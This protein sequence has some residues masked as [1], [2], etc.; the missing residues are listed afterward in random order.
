M[1]K[2]SAMPRLD[3]KVAMVTDAAQGI[4]LA[5]DEASYIAGEMIYCHGV[6]IPLNDAVP[7]VN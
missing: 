4:G 5:S 2:G 1:A 3:G 7:V 6:R